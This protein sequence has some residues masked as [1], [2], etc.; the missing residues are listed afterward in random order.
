MIPFVIIWSVWCLSEV[1]L[2]RFFL[3]DR[4]GNN[5]KDKG[6]LR[7]IWIAIG[8]AISLGVYFSRAT[9]LPISTISIMP[10]LG[11]LIIVIGMIFRLIAIMTLGNFFTVNLT[12]RDN[13]QIKK[14]GLYKLLRHPSYT[15]SILSF[16]GFGISLNNW[17]SLIVIAIL[18]VSAMLYRIK[19]EED[20]LTDHF[21]SEYIDYAEK[22]YRLIPWIY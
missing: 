22:T 16:I 12:I 2:N 11:L 17:I 5:A 20:L 1:F 13:H 21:G 3:A 9:N 18:V 8:F 6:S 19:V 7:I 14:D 4:R 10:Y 15:G